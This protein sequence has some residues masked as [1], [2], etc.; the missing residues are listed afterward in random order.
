MSLSWCQAVF[1]KPKKPKCETL[2]FLGFFKKPKKP[3]FFKTTFDSPA[4][5]AVWTCCGNLIESFGYH[6]FCPC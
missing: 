4:I 1:K 3:R 5:I 2:G 6:G